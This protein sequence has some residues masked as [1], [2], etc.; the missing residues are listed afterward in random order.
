MQ[1]A[2]PVRLPDEASFDSFHVHPGVAPAVAQ[3]QEGLAHPPFG[4]CL[5]GP[6]QSG[7]THLLQATA[8]AAA[9]LDW[10]VVYLPLAD[11]RA[12]PAEE[13]LEGLGESGLVCLDDVDAV[14]GDAAWERAL[15]GLYNR[16][17]GAGASLLLAAVRPPVA[18]GIELPD[19]RS[20]LQALLVLGLAP[21]DD[22]DRSQALVLQARARGMTLEPDVAR[23]ILARAPRGMSEL[24]AA[25]DRLDRSSLAAG[26]RLSIPFVRE[27][28]G[29]VGDS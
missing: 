21:P 1:L 7:R 14:A 11:L 18:L 28:L 26:R 3:V 9:A 13:L 19:L 25:L 8:H 29:W 4:I 27:A 5:H 17:H 10:A 23:Y 24:V 16:V 2:L 12:Q 6:A 22:D 15:F 20:R